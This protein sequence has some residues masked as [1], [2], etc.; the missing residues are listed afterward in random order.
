MQANYAPLAIKNA[1]VELEVI[2]PEVLRQPPALLNYVQVS[3]L[4]RR[5]ATGILLVSGDPR[6]FYG[7]LF[8]SSR[9]FVDFLARKVGVI[10][11]PGSSFYARGGGKTKARFNFAKKESTLEEAAR[12]L[13]AA[14]LRASRR[15]R[16]A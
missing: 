10:A 4:Y 8:N 5:I 14:N 15:R 11:V 16:S 3:R 12:R 1:G 7:N 9:A 2:M 13:G 6:D